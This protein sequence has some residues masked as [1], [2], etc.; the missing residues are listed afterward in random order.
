MWKW[1]PLA[2]D[3]EKQQHKRMQSSIN[4]FR[5]KNIWWASQAR[6]VNIV[7]VDFEG[8][9]KSPFRKAQGDNESW[10]DFHSWLFIKD[11]LV[12]SVWGLY[13]PHTFIPCTHEGRKCIF[14]PYSTCN[15]L[16]W[17]SI[18]KRGYFT[19]INMFLYIKAHNMHSFI[20]FFSIPRELNVVPA[21][22]SLTDKH[23]CW[24]A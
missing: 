19:F 20:Q 10:T 21:W 4:K 11:P 15:S 16:A 14:I 7:Q 13:N 6:N 22:G 12:L 9:L 24:N 18:L 8:A 17:I 3:T 5:F 2:S 23:G 1:Y